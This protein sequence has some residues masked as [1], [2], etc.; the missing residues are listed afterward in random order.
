MRATRHRFVKTVE[1]SI[2]GLR[3][4]TWEDIWQFIYACDDTGVERVWGYV[5]RDFPDVPLAK[6]N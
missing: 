5:S 2:P 1:T 6:D 4:G 3:D